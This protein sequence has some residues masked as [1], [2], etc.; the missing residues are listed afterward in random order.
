[1]PEGNDAVPT[2]DGDPASFEGFC[3]SCRWYEC[4]LKE[5]E[6]RLAAPRIWQRLQGSAKSVV[7]CQELGAE[8]LRFLDRPGKAAGNLEGV[9]TSEAAH[10]GFVP[11]VGEVVGDEA[12]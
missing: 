8:G 11:E 9:A 7:S 10:P 6:R 4:S 5:S 12:H 1:M 3:T 2:W